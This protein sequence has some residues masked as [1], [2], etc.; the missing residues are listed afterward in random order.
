MLRICCN[1]TASRVSAV[2]IAKPLAHRG[3]S[4]E[5]NHLS[6]KPRTPSKWNLE[7]MITSKKSAQA[8]GPLFST[9]DRAIGPE[10]TQLYL[11]PYWSSLAALYGKR[12]PG[13]C[14]V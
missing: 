14:D 5:P 7:D 8:L 1:Q 2:S 12:I 13:M 9:A 6:R 11:P 3:L 4:H 10:L